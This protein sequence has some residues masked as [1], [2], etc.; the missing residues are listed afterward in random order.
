MGLQ[1]VASHELASALN[2]VLEHPQRLLL[3]LQP[4]A[5]AKKFR[6]AHI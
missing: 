5:L 1:I 6:R 4:C 2:E 3:R